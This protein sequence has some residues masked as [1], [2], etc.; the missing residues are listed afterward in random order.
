M[1][2][3]GVLSA[4]A[5]ELPLA[6]FLDLSKE[7]VDFESIV[8][9]LKGDED[10]KSIPIVAFTGHVNTEELARASDWGCMATTNGAVSADFAGTLARAL[11]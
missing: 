5:K 11:G 10:T 9:Q 3:A 6:I 1:G 8:K 2:A 7:D 4:V